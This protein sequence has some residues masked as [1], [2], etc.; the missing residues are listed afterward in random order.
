MHAPGELTPGEVA[1]Y[2]P[3]WELDPDMFTPCPNE[4]S[5]NWYGWNW[6]EFLGKG[7]I[8]EDLRR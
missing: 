7:N 6:D 3:E 5:R 4:D 2:D 8:R 1:V